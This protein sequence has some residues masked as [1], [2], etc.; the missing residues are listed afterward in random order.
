MQE[1]IKIDEKNLGKYIQQGINL[2][3]IITISVDTAIKNIVTP[4]VQRSVSIAIKTTKQL[5]LKDFSMEPSTEK[6]IRGIELILKYFAG[7]LALVT[8]RE[9]FRMDLDNQL[10]KQLEAR[11]KLDLK[12]IQTIVQI[13]CMD[14]L[15]IG[16]ALIKKSV[17]TKAL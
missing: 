11:T 4:V 15:D 14:N 8:C 17:I 12:N 16:C 6:L 9:L 3:E 7:S 10:K 13:A 1:Y 5:A 2:K